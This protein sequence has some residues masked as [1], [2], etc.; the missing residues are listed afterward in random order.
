VLPMQLTP[1]AA[2]VAIFVAILLLLLRAI[3]RAL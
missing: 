2:V 3:Y 1:A